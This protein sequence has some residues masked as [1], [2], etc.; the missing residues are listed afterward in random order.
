MS[1]PLWRA[2]RLMML[3]LL[4]A[5]AAHAQTDTTPPAVTLNSAQGT[6]TFSELPSP[7]AGQ[8]FDAGG[9]GNLTVSLSRTYNGF[10]EFWNGSAWVSAGPPRWTATLGAPG[11]NHTRTWSVAPTWPSGSNLPRGAYLLRVTAQDAAGN[12]ADTLR[13]VNIGAADE[14]AP[15]ISFLSPTDEFLLDTSQGTLSAISGKSS[16]GD[17]AGVSVVTVRISRLWTGATEYWDGTNWGSARTN[18]KTALSARNA[19]G[20][21]PWSVSDAL[22]SVAQWATG[23]YTVQAFATD[24]FGNSSS[25]SQGLNVAPRDDVAPLVGITFPAPDQTLYA[26]PEI[27]GGASDDAS[28]VANVV[29]YLGRT[30]TDASGASALQ[31]WNGQSWDL[32]FSTAC[33]L[34]SRD[35]IGWTRNQTLPTGAD[36]APGDY[37]VFCRAADRYRNTSDTIA[38][39]FRIVPIPPLAIDAQI[40]ASSDD[41]N[42][43]NGG[44]NGA[45][46]GESIVNTT[47][48]GQTLQRAIG[49]GT[50]QISEVKV[51]LRGGDSSKTVTVRATDWAAFA[52]SD[53]SA[54][55]FDEAGTNITAAITGANGVALTMSAGDER[56]IRIDTSAPAGAA[57]GALQ[58]LTLRAS[59]NPTSETPAID[60]VKAIWKATV[61]SQPDALIRAT[62]PDDATADYVGNDLYNADGAN[63]SAQSVSI[64]GAPV[65]FDVQ[66]QNDGKSATPLAVKLPAAPAAPA[67][68]N[69]QLFDGLTNGTDISAAAQSADGWSS[70]TIAPGAQRELRLRMTPTVNAVTS[71]SVK[72]SVNSGTLSDSV[73]ASV[74][75]QSIAKI[76][77]S[78]DGQTWN[79]AAQTP[80]AVEKYEVIAFRAIGSNPDIAWDDLP[81][82]APTWNSQG[83]THWGET[84]WI[85]FP[86]LG[87]T[88]VSALC[89]ASKTVTV[90]VTETS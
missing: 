74:P 23:R 48:A 43:A 55:F 67:G 13:S 68:W 51:A 81:G 77:W 15:T 54:Q 37:T 19:H 28:G 63:Q 88:T 14:T 31:F 56:T 72:L 85:D 60:V 90:I 40:R 65:S 20:F 71:A 22:P 70:P 79:D 3:A 39:N 44:A 57:A 30:V 38:Q 47:A 11:A 1:S 45:W 80:L 12:H 24:R 27:R 61:T 69:V 84:I 21:S 89:G 26:L 18:L 82:F 64:P 59:T 16:D 62:P 78:R 53:W 29:V 10:S 42:G 52:A 50:T 2:F 32:N 5:S 17:G 46:L 33:I 83:Q 6:T 36:L 86:K 87:T 66:L 25:V 4:V 73:V 34:P 7:L 41:A 76:Q 9:M 35:E 8:V 49:A 75:V 58:T